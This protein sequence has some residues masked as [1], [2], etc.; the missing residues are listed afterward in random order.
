[1]VQDTFSTRLVE[2]MLDVLSI[3]FWLIILI[4]IV[5]TIFNSVSDFVSGSPDPGRQ[6]RKYHRRNNK[7]TNYE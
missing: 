7:Y 1:M 2:I 3:I 4:A 6:Y 5:L